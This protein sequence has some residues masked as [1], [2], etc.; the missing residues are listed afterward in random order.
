MLKILRIFI[1]T[2]S[3]IL[4]QEYDWSDTVDDKYAY[5]R[6]GGP[7][8]PRYKVLLTNLNGEDN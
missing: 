4:S 1:P 7:K 6:M 2:R 5:F 3:R 8:G